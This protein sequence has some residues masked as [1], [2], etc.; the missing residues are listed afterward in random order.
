MILA[1]G[2]IFEI[3]FSIVKSSV[4]GKNSPKPFKISC[5]FKSI[6]A[7][8]KK[9]SLIKDFIP[10]ITCF[11]VA[12]LKLLYILFTATIPDFGKSSIFLLCVLLDIFYFE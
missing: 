1:P 9:I 3:W 6:L 7:P 12:R 8:D 5:I 2:N 11:S 10:I 4:P